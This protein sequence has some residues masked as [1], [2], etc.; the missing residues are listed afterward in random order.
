M[1]AGP[2]V[3]RNQ[4]ATVYVGGFDEKVSEEVLWE[5]FL[6]AGRV[7][8]IHLPK[9]RISQAHQG[10][11]FVELF[12]EDDADY[13]VRIMNMIK[14]YGKPIRVNKLFG[15]TV[16]CRHYD[17]NV[18][19]RPADPV[20]TRPT[21]RRGFLLRC[22]IG[23]FEVVDA[24]PF[25]LSWNQHAP[26]DIAGRVPSSYD[27]LV[28]D[29]AAVHDDRNLTSR[30]GCRTSRVW[31]PTNCQRSS[32]IARPDNPGCFA[33]RATRF[34]KLNE[35][36]TPPAAFHR[37]TSYVLST[38]VWRHHLLPHIVR[39]WRLLEEKHIFISQAL[40]LSTTGSACH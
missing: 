11:G 35:L 3:T 38:T 19:D 26:V 23:S 1:A 24:A 27:L 20:S 13:A 7:V 2:I 34:S 32:R 12:D 25:A 33:R 17:H 14:L 10:Y 28:R 5:L 39:S 31:P 40:A 9:D 36:P 18:A 8:G 4:A 29:A 22:T 16:E 21:F 37:H 6:Q 15:K 30:L